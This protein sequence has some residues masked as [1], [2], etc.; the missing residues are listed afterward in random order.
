MLALIFSLA[1][2]ATVAAAGTESVAGT[3]VD[4][5]AGASMPKGLVVTLQGVGVTHQITVRQTAAVSSD[6]RFSF[7]D[8]PSDASVTYVVSTTY[9]GV[10][11][12]TAIPRANGQ[13]IGPIQIKI[14]EPTTSDA[15]I[16]VLSQNWLL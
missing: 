3:V 15:A 14:Y 13:A 9:A 10:P 4:G 8:V 7:A 6:G 1:S 12:L 5:T 2:L 11:Y 16:Q